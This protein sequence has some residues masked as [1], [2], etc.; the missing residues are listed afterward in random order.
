MKF[1]DV[2]CDFYAVFIIKA[3]YDAGKGGM[4]EIKNGHEFSQKIRKLNEDIDEGFKNASKQLNY[5]DL[6][7][8]QMH[9]KQRR[10]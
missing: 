10:R 1:F 4:D 7:R 5:L 8:A 2:F 3:A 6:V 9:W